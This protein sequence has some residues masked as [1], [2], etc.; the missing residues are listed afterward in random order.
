MAIELVDLPSY[1]M[2]IC[3][4]AMLVYQ[5]VTYDHV[6]NFGIRHFEIDRTSRK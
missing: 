2:L 6:E 1:K 3:Q 4:F 5:R